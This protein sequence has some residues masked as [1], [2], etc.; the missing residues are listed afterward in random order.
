MQFKT[1]KEV[2]L[3]V[4]HEVPK[5]LGYEKSSMFSIDETGKNLCAIS[6]DEE[7]E[8]I[9][10]ES[11]VGLGFEKEFVIDITQI[12]RF[13]TTL[14]LTGLAFQHNAVTYLNNCQQLLS[15]ESKRVYG[16]LFSKHEQKV[17]VYD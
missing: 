4:R 10:R 16:N 11:Y 13:P 3:S 6:L 5:I 9:E 15:F 14:G 2:L 7:T 8:N 12:V 1:Q 17:P